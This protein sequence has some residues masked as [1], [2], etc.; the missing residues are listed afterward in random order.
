MNNISAEERVKIILEGMEQGQE[1]VCEKYEI[2][3]KEFKQWKDKLIADAEMVFAAE[4]K[5]ADKVDRAVRKALRSYRLKAN[6]TR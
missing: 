5:I 6:R 2:S 1:A 4:E 3:E